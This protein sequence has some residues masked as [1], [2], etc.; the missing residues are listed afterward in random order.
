MPPSLRLISFLGTGKYG[1]TTYHLDEGEAQRVTTQFVTLAL[2][3]LLGATEVL[4][5][6]TQ[7][8]E[9]KHGQAL[10]AAFVAAG[11]PSPQFMRVA[12]G[13]TPEELWQGFQVL[14]GLIGEQTSQRL[15]LDITHGFRSQPFFAAAVVGFVR[16]LPGAGP[17]ISVWY[18]A[19]ESRSADGPTGRSPIW[20]LTAFTELVDWSQSLGH[21]LRTGDARVAAATAERIG[22]E[23]KKVWASTREGDPPQIVQFARA[24]EEFSDALVTVRVGELL[25][26]RTQGEKPGEGPART[27][28]LLTAIQASRPDLERRI[29]PVAEVL[30]RLVEMVKPLQLPDGMTHLADP[31]T[32]DAQ[33]ALARLYWS[34]GRYAESAAVLREAWVNRF[35]DAVGARPGA[36]RFDTEGR[37]S[38]EDAWR[39]ADKYGAQEI[40]D[41]RNDI[42]HAGFR[43]DPKPPATIRNQIERLI[44]R[45]EQTAGRRPARSRTYFVTR[46]PGAREWAAEEG[47]PVDDIIEHLDPDQIQRGDTLIGSLPVNLAAAVCQRGARYLHLSLNLT[48]GLRGLELSAADLRACGARLEEFRVEPV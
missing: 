37:K 38:A 12:D 26:A 29:P 22:R 20:N 1:E 24:L 16:A 6:C 42:E 8:A 9:D 4:V 31:K 47:L 27:Q 41:V 44:Q 43:A 13:R 5:V 39:G 2:A 25:L 45:L 17:D 36:V 10:A 18:G 21:F 32:D 19:Y 35:A 34:L 14:R 48:P 11:R 46:H 23:L 15:A 30:D 7:A 33:A 28:A 40:S 3:Q